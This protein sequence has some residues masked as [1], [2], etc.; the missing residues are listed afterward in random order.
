MFAIDL[1]KTGSLLIIVKCPILA[2][3]VKL[4]CILLSIYVVIKIDDIFL[5][6]ECSSFRFKQKKQGREHCIA[7]LLFLRKLSLEAGVLVQQLRL[8]AP[9]QWLGVHRFRSWAW[10]QHHSSSHTVAAS[11]I[12]NRGR[13]A[14]MLAQGQSSSHTQKIY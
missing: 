7:E 8:R 11:H 6:W 13:L 4:W 5:E 14:Q 10:T 3:W 12:Q 1:L 2:E 9:L